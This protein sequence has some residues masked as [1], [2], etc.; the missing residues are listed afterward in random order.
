MWWLFLSVHHSS[1]KYDGDLSEYTSCAAMLRVMW[2]SASVKLLRPAC[3]G[4][5]IA[6]LFVP[7]YQ[8]TTAHSTWARQ[9]YR[10]FSDS[11]PKIFHQTELDELFWGLHQL[12]PA[13]PV[14]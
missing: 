8:A 7:A 4:S 14:N 3:F 2:S 6:A 10:G 5:A 13:F 9:E 11:R 1:L 12:A